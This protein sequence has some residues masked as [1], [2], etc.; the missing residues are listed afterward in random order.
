[1]AIDA[2]IDKIN[3]AIARLLR[4]TFERNN[5]TTFLEFISSMVHLTDDF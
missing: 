3:A 1:M 4:N 2:N 5:L